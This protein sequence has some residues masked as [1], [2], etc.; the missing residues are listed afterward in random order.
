MW[1]MKRLDQ[2]NTTTKYEYLGRPQKLSLPDLRKPADLVEPMEVSQGLIED[3]IYLGD[4]GMAIVAGTPVP[5]KVQTPAMFCAPERFHNVNPSF[6]SDMWSYMCILTKLY[7]GY[8]PFLSQPGLH[9]ISVLVNSLGP[10]PEHWK[11]YYCADCDPIGSEDSWYDQSKKPSFFSL[12]S[13]LAAREPA[14]SQWEQDL[15]L[16][17]LSKVFRYEPVDRLTAA[18]LLADTDFNELMRIYGC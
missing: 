8:E 6:A 5:S 15:V 12:A 10:L 2:Y 4:F 11:G 1:Q 3:R 14:V 7:I 13:R 18:E 9:I 16:S 17:V